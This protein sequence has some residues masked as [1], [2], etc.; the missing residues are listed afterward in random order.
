MQANSGAMRWAAQYVSLGEMSTIDGPSSSN[1][2]LLTPASI[3]LTNSLKTCKTVVNETSLPCRRSRA[4]LYC[5]PPCMLGLLCVSAVLPSP[6]PSSYV[7]NPSSTR[8]TQASTHLIPTN[9]STACTT[10][11]QNILCCNTV[12]QDLFMLSKLIALHKGLKLRRICSRNRAGCGFVCCRSR[13][14]TFPL[15]F[16]KTLVVQAPSLRYMLFA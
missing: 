5:Q 14:R 15:Y 6:V 12:G 3:W 8:H 7:L 10:G 16:E 2:T 13:A 9:W 4:W 1:N 11:T